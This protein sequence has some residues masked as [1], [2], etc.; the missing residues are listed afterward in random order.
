ML[1]IYADYRERSSN[2]A[3]HLVKRNVKVFFEN[4]ETCDYV[5]S[6]RL[7]VER[8][9]VRDLV[10]SLFD[11]RLFSQ[12]S[13]MVERFEKPIIIIEG[14]FSEVKALT[15]KV[16]AV[17][18]ALTSLAIEMNVTILWSPTSEGTADILYILAKHEQE[19]KKRL[20]TF[21]PKKPRTQDVK[22]WQLRIL[23][24]FP[25]IGPKLAEKLLEKFGS[26]EK[27]FTSSSTE[28]AKVVGYEKAQKMLQLLKAPYS[29]KTKGYR[30]DIL[31]YFKNGG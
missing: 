1:R 25:G 16:N 9:T 30:E 10:K 13:R 19:E 7:C 12:A 21:V 5:I 31:K 27:V 24:S 15:D 22:E 18:G 28:L 4:L 14:D 20:R 8:K 11:G 29:G 2:I 26:L 23:Q 17:F 3:K 6:D